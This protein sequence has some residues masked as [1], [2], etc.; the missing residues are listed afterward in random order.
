M[1]D[2]FDELKKAYEALKQQGKR[3]VDIAAVYEETRD[4][5]KLH[6]KYPLAAQF[7]HSFSK[8]G[9]KQAG[10]EFEVLKEDIEQYF[11]S[12]RND[13]EDEDGEDACMDFD[14]LREK[15][16]LFD[17]REKLERMWDNLGLEEYFT[18]KC[19]EYIVDGIVNSKKQFKRS[20]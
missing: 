10:I 1:A 12:E 7:L 19:K 3:T 15:L 4:S 20:D 13:E 18:E 14:E 16:D 11:T 2:K 6:D 5:A 8:D 9:A 17:T